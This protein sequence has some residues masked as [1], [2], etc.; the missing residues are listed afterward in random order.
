MTAMAY[1]QEDPVARL[2][3]WLQAMDVT[4]RDTTAKLRSNEKNRLGLLLVHGVFALAV[5]PGFA[6][7]LSQPHG[8]DSASFA[9]FRHI[10]GAPYTLAFILGLGGAI[11]I[12]ATIARHRMWEMTGLVLLMAWYGAMALCF[13]VAFLPWAYGTADPA[14]MPSTYAS[15]VY[16]HFLT[17]MAVHVR[18]LWKMRRG[19]GSP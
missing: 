16:F 3:A 18:T 6:Y 2:A 7:Q 14:A 11:L 1:D 13:A 9:P 4:G 17:I 5:A 12:P 19:Q 8:M 10:P 15:Q